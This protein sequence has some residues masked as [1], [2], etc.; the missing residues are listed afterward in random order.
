VADHRTPVT[1][2]REAGH[3]VADDLGRE[4]QEGGRLDAAHPVPQAQ[5]HRRA[6]HRRLARAVDQVARERPARGLAGDRGEPGV[7][8]GGDEP[9]GAERAEHAR[10]RE[11][12]HH[13]RG[14]EPVRHGAGLVGR[15]D[16]VVAA[17]TWGAQLVRG[18]RRRGSQHG[19]PRPARE[20]RVAGEPD[21]GGVA[22]HVD[23]VFQ[24]REHRVD[25]VG[26][27]GERG[28]ALVVTAGRRGVEDGRCHHGGAPFSRAS[29]AMPVSS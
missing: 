3:P 7:D 18:Q 14:R 6:L 8:L 28:A 29:A 11:G 2:G 16:A 10:P 1:A 23:G 19:R 21:P 24:V 13:L 25:G 5:V 22:D 9:G 17:E 4:L 20:A 27:P 26:G 12:H 15:P